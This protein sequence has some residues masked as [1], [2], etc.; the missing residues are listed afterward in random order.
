MKPMTFI[1]RILK[2]WYKAKAVIIRVLEKWRMKTAPLYS[3]QYVDDFPDDLKPYVIYLLG[4]PGKEWLA[5]FSCPCGCG[6]KIELVLHGRS[7]SWK[8]SYSKDKRP[9]LSP[10]VYRSVNCRSHF[11][12]ERGRIR[13][14]KP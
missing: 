12:L 8:L 6:D 14:C 9:N 2:F 4:Q 7:P 13:W 1:K 3:T 5:G 11:F 10:S